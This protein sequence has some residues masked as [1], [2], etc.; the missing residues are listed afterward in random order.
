[1]KRVH[2]NKNI[3]TNTDSDDDYSDNESLSNKRNKLSFEEHKGKYDLVTKEIINREITMNDVFKLDLPMEEY[4]WFTEYIKILK[5]TEPN[6]EE[7]YRVKNMIYQRYTTLKNVD[8]VKLNKIKNDSGVENDI[9]SKILNSDHPDTVKA[10]LYRKYKRCYDNIGTGGTSD[11]FFKIIDWIDNVL[12]LP[13]KVNH[14]VDSTTN[15]KLIKLWKALNSNISG[16]MNVKEKVME[17]MCA[18]L[19]DPDN[20][21]KIL[22]FVGPPGVGKTAVAMS[23]AESLGL[24][25][26]QISFGSVKDSVVLTG[27]SSTYIGAIPGLFTKILLKSKQLDT[28]VLLDEIDKIPDTSEGKSISS[29]LLH[30]LDRTQNHRFRDMYMPEI[31][32]DLSKMI[33]LA[34]ANS[35]ESIDPVLRDRMTIIEIRGYTIDEK[36]EICMKHLFPRI[37]R[38]LGFDDDLS[39]TESVIKHLILNK[40]DNQPGMRDVERKTYQLCERLSLLKHAKGLKFSYKINNVKFPFKIDIDTVNILL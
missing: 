17:A 13:T 12:D 22:T 10:I 29:V 36:V 35:L 1:M 14:K 38:E 19:L 37:K 21:G 16:L 4:I 8:F 27:H 39:I 3:N 28:V 34:A 25:F 20:K 5:S 6:T 40:T 24:P 30:V 26:D 32:L 31:V 7:R 33:F 2:K 9:V 15:E 18:K 11:E 23:I